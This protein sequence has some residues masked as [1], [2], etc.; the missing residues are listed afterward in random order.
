V[1]KKKNIQIKI[2]SQLSPHISIC[3][4]LISWLASHTCPG[5]SKSQGQIWRPINPDLK[6]IQA[7][8]LDLQEG[9]R[10]SK[11]K[12]D[13]QHFKSGVDNCSLIRKCVLSLGKKNQK[14]FFNMRLHIENPY[15]YESLIQNQINMIWF[16]HM[17]KYNQYDQNPNPYEIHIEDA[18]WKYF[19]VL[20]NFSQC[21]LFPRTFVV[22]GTVHRL[23]RLA[24]KGQWLLIKIS[25]YTHLL[26]YV[27][28]ACHLEG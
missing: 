20:F 6:T 28:S 17:I 19:L 4:T 2:C 9:P 18:Y 3:L 24:L 11:R 27:S 12:I 15:Q 22:S 8:W 1:S 23:T 26:K 25:L 16:Y 13:K 5:T 21:L 10:L 7:L 14:V